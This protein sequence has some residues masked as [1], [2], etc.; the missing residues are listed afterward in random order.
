AAAV[1]VRT[2]AA[3]SRLRTCLRVNNETYGSRFCRNPVGG[4]A[5]PGERVAERQAQGAFVGEGAAPAALRRVGRG[6]GPPRA[7]AARA[8]HAVLRRAGTPRG[9]GASRRGRALP[10]RARV[11]ARSGGARGGVPR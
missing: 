5:L 10:G 8:D 11:R 2:R 7:V 1:P 6:G 3:A 9:R 4:A